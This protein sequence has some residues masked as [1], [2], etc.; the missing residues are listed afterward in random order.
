MKK[1]EEEKSKSVQ[2]GSWPSSYLKSHSLKTNALKKKLKAKTKA[3]I[4]LLSMNC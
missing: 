3:K 4:S 1:R 2:I